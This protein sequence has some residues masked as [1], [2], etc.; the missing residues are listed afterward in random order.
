MSV[1]SMSIFPAL[2]LI[3]LLIHCLCGNESPDY[4]RVDCQ[5]STSDCVIDAVFGS[6]QHNGSVEVHIKCASHEQLSDIQFSEIEW[7]EWNGCNAPENIKSLGLGKILRKRQVKSMKIEFFAVGGLESETFMGFSGLETLSLE[8]N[9]IQTL[10]SSCF[11]GLDSLKALKMIEKNL[12]WVDASVLSDLNKLKVLEIFS[13]EH[14]RM[15][16]LQFRENQI[17]D[18]VVMETFIIE[19]DL[20][21]HLAAHVRNL[22]IS[23]GVDEGLIECFQSRLNGFRRDWILETLR[24]DGISCGFIMENVDSIKTLELNGAMRT[25][26]SEFKLKDLR[27]LQALKLHENIFENFSSFKLEG[28]F[29]K[30]EVLNLANNT[31]TAIDMR[32]FEALPSLKKINLSGNSLRKLDEMN[33]R[34]FQ[35]VELVV[36][37]NMLDCPWLD[38]IASS[39]V[40]GKFVYEKNFSGLNVGG[41][42]CLERPPQSP[43]NETLCLSHFIDPVNNEALL[44]GESESRSGPETLMIIVAS[45]LLGAAAAFISIYLYHRRQMLNQKPFYHLLRDSFV[46][47]ISSVRIT[48][49]RD[50]KEIISRNLPPTNYE[51]PISEAVTEMTDVETDTTNI[52]EEIPSKLYQ[53]IM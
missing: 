29:D 1:E 34:K 43:A 20:M 45:F 9:S 23:M 3:S 38:A 25:P 47:P 26:Y 17:V 19:M 44:R 53:E 27:N 37:G 4:N 8:F 32:L 36:D 51:H 35:N 11:R 49:R 13:G 28:R 15:A 30:L 14:L 16:N 24:V 18:N 39:K 52:Y 21:E 22:S 42:L 33:L 2:F 40:F 48:L 50:L 7:I 5:H 10:S 46:R 6:I 41:L 12:K 31:M